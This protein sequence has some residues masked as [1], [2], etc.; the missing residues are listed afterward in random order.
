MYREDLILEHVLHKKVLDCGG[1]D[2]Y[3]FEQ[4]LN[5]KEW[6][7]DKIVDQ[8][9]EC[10]GVDIL[11]HRVEQINKL[12]KYHFIEANVE[13]LPFKEEF[14]VVVAGEIVEHL[15]NCGHF[16]ESAW[17]ALNKDG[18]LIITT[19]NS[20]SFSGMIYA[21]FFRSENCHPEHVCFYSPQTLR[22][23]LERH[24]F[25]VTSLHCISRPARS[26]M[27]GWI[28]SLVTKWNPLLG[29][30]IVVIATKNEIKPLYSGIW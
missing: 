24:G 26:K 14:E 9:K 16:L 13:N 15:H 7:H 23:L 12:G 29:E 28:R 4:K 3:A 6:L 27:V 10:I 20:F 2:H 11:K 18:K 30:I 21:I 25:S 8:A 19:P 1:A 17:R 22:Y 5:A